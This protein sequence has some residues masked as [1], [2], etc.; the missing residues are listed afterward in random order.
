MG[1]G[2]A[3]GGNLRTDHE[4]TSPGKRDGPAPDI[5]TSVPNS[6]WVERLCGRVGRSDAPGVLVMRRVKIAVRGD[7]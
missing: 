6:Q 4:G 7:R 5:V 3:S 2:A 1:G